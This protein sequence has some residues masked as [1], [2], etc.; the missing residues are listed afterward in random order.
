M[1]SSRASM[2]SAFAR[3]K[4]LRLMSKAFGR[5]S[6]APCRGPGVSQ[7]KGVPRTPDDLKAH[8]C[9][10]HRFPDGSSDGRSVE[11]AGIESAA[12]RMAVAEHAPAAASY[13]RTRPGVA[14]LP[15]LRHRPATSRRPAVT[16]LH[17]LSHRPTLRVLA[18][19][20][21]SFPAPERRRLSRRKPGPR[22][23]I[24]YHAARPGSAVG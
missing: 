3:L 21:P 16:A 23:E 22:A 7:V 4:T 15:G 24:A 5:V 17:D 1:S 10:H 13:G 20:P 6:P 12:A 8:A 18:V 19:E 14:Y 9:L 2:L 11:H